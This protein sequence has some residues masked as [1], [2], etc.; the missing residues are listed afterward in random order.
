MIDGPDLISSK[1]R[2]PTEAFF[3][4]TNVV[5]D[6]KDPFGRTE[7]DKSI[8]RRHETIVNIVDVLKSKGVS[9]LG[10]LGVVLE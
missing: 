3:V 4:D 8:E 6:F 5:I 10:T 1:R 9:A 2:L 7:T